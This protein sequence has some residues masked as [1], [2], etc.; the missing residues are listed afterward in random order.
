MK[1][2]F[3]F[4]AV[5]IAIPAMTIPAAAWCV[6][7]QW[8][9]YYVVCP[10]PMDYVDPPKQSHEKAHHPVP[11]S[12]S[13]SDNGRSNTTKRRT[14][15]HSARVAAVRQPRHAH[16]VARQQWGDSG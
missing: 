2:L 15:K 9:W 12:T 13:P 3:M 7:G 5:V 8:G 14:S 4:G 11:Y 10:A 16:G 1:T 6:A